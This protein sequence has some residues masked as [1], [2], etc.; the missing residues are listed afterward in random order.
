MNQISLK[1]ITKKYVA[2]GNVTVALNNIL[3]NIEQGEMVAVMGPSGSGKTTMLNILGC[4]DNPSEGQLFLKTEKVELMDE[5]ELS[6]VRNKNIGFVF[7]QFALIDDYT[8]LENVE[9]PLIYR[10][11]HDKKSKLS[12]K[13]I[14]AK[15][16]EVLD[17]LGIKDHYYKYPSQLSGGQQQRV[18]IARALIGEPDIIIADEPTGALDQKTGVEVMNLLLDINKKG[19]TVIIVT[20]DEKVAT[21]CKRRVDILDG[22]IVSDKLLIN[23][24]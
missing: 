9:L 4:L 8:V 16:F 23:E 17:S 5:D 18:A 15:V 12:R 1:N 21:Y 6:K 13:E 11:L 2:Y 3:L 24:V 7:Q 19:K 10:K 14:K 20:H 22:N